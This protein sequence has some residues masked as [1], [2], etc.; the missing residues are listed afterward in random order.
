MVVVFCVLIYFFFLFFTWNC[1]LI[2][3][4]FPK[5]KHAADVNGMPHFLKVR[6]V[7]AGHAH[8]M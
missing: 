1:N 6:M 3:I 5:I 8:M 4:P 7:H 2:S